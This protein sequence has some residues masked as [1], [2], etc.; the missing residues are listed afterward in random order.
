MACER[1]CNTA[2]DSDRQSP[3]K[4]RADRNRGRLEETLLRIKECQRKAENYT[5]TISSSMASS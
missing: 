3:V 5:I 4:G 1:W 2:R